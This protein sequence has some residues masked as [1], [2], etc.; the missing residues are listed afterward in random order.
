MT[1]RRGFLLGLGATLA[2][3]AI[4]RAEVL[5]PVR[6]LLMPSVWT[7]TSLGTNSPLWNELFF[8]G[9]AVI[10]WHNGDVTLTST[11]NILESA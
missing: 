2:A 4:V 10:H 11:A 5:M 3:P 8:A 6:K 9:G 7:V 1:S